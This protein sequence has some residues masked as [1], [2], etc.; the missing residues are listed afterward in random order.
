MIRKKSEQM[1]DYAVLFVVI[2][3]V[4]TVSGGIEIAMRGFNPWTWLIVLAAWNLAFLF[5]QLGKN[6]RERGY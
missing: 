5:F 6:Y 2:F 4:A 3:V 1:L